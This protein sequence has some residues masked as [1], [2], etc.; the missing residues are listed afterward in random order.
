MD[1][2]RASFLLNYRRIDS[3]Q[4]H[5]AVIRAKTREQAVRELVNRWTRRGVRITIGT[6]HNV[7]GDVEATA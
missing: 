4:S 3:N 6:I 2:G 5:E 7:T 1:R